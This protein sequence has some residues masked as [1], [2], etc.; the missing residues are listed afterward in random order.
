ME[1]VVNGLQRGYSDVEIIDKAVAEGWVKVI[2]PSGPS[3]ERVKRVEKRMGVELGAG[4]REALALALDLNANLVLTNN[5]LAY[6]AASIL[7]LEAK[8]LLYVLLQAVSQSLLSAG[9]AWRALEDMVYKGFW[10]S[11]DLVAL[12]RETLDKMKHAGR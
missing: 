10:L 11:P 4:E 6:S 1:A 2:E 5:E 9:E 12:F 3:I 7:G 8:G